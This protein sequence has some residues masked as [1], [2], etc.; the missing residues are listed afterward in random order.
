MR[1]A[2]EAYR[3][4]QMWV[5]CSQ[6][7]SLTSVKQN[8]TT[9][10]QINWSPAAVWTAVDVSIDPWTLEASQC[11]QVRQNRGQHQLEH[12]IKHLWYI[13]IVRPPIRQLY[14]TSGNSHQVMMTT[15]WSPTAFHIRC[16]VRGAD[17]KIV[18]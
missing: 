12:Y 9:I 7:P 1:R 10:H 8:Y 6:V 2:L 17:R 14:V 13:S 5:T 3:G 16:H 15:A 4:G 11:R 18:P